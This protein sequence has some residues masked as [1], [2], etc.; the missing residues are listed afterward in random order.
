VA[1]GLL[2][3]RKE[4][5]RVFW[6]KFGGAVGPSLLLVVAAFGLGAGAVGWSI[7]VFGVLLG[8][9]VATSARTYRGAL[10][11]GIAVALVLLVFQIVVAWFITH[12]VEKS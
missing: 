9:L 8:F 4:R 11:A 7:A 6:L 5:L 12:P 3:T 1:D 10:I 2:L